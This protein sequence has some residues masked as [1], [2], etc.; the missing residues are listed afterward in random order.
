M[1]LLQLMSDR[2]DSTTFYQERWFPMGQ[3]HCNTNPLDWQWSSLIV[4]RFEAIEKVVS[5]LSVVERR[6][7]TDGKLD[8]FQMRASLLASASALHEGVKTRKAES[9]SDA[10]TGTDALPCVANGVTGLC[11]GPFNPE[12]PSV[13]ETYPT[14]PYCL[15]T[16]K[17]QSASPTRAEADG[18]LP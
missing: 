16:R 11:Q 7:S 13:P 10:L 18:V 17:T 1:S 4:V 15:G 5:Q 2:D 9:C 3:S 6:R 8:L 14:K 12:M